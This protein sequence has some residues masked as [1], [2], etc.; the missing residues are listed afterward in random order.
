MRRLDTFSLKDTRVPIHVMILLS[1]KAV[2]DMRVINYVQGQNFREWSHK[3]I[4]VLRHV[5]LGMS[6]YWCFHPSLSL[7]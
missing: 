1:F 6:V 3:K 4:D 2:A 5:K 7:I